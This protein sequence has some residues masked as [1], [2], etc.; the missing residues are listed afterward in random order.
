MLEPT[1]RNGLQYDIRSLP[2]SWHPSLTRP[3]V[4]SLCCL[5][6]YHSSSIW[7]VCFPTSFGM[8][9]TRGFYG[10][11][12]VVHIILE[13]ALRNTHDS[14]NAS[15]RN[16]LSWEATQFLPR[17]RCLWVATE[18]FRLSWRPQSRHLWW[19]FSTTSHSIFHHIV[20]T[21]SGTN[22]IGFHHETPQKTGTELLSSILYIKALPP[23]AFG[24]DREQVRLALAKEKIAARPVWKPL[25]LQPVFAECECMGGAVAEELFEYGLCLPSGSNLTEEDLERVTSAILGL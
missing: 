2:E 4:Y 20:R 3:I 19:K 24:A 14:G 22:Q 6:S 5:L 18:D 10:S 1:S 23:A 8:T 21:T 12:Q 16:P 11:V 9:V 13:P 15:K 7:T 17:C 25:H